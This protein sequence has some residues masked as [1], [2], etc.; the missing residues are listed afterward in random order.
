M[1]RS[2]N[3]EAVIPLRVSVPDIFCHG[4]AITID[5]DFE[6]QRFFEILFYGCGGGRI[7]R[8]ALV[9]DWLHLVSC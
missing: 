1:L 8:D 9:Y 6:L 2:V 4:G 3:I 7:R 5:L